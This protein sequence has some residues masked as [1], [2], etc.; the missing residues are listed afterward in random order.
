V[1]APA[2]PPGPV[3]ERPPW[4]LS[5][6]PSSAYCTELINR[7]TCV[8]VS[9]YVLTRDAAVTEANDAALEELVS[10]VGLKISDPFFRETVVSGYSSVRANLLAALQSA[11]LDPASAAYAA[12]AA[13]VIQARKRVV[14]VFRASGGAAVPTQRSDWYWE[15]YGHKKGGVETLVFVRYDVT[16]DAIRALVETYAATTPVL[17][18]AAMTA[19]PALAWQDAAFAGGAM[20]TKVGRALGEAGVAPQSVVTAVGQVRVTDAPSLRRRLED[21]AAPER[22]ALTVKTGDAPARTVEIRRPLRPTR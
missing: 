11:E 19:F 15:E 4:I 1:A 18:G 17:G 7:L 14:E 8:G 16:L 12:A 3:F 9:S 10:A 22:I 5:D 2:K 6:A 20:L 21:D 13:A